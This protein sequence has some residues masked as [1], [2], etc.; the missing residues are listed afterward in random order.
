MLPSSSPEWN[1]F[2]PATTK[3]HG[4]V[5]ADG[6][7]CALL[8]HAQQ[9]VFGIAIPPLRGLRRGTGRG[10]WRLSR[11]ALVSLEGSASS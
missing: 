11:V 9:N 8:E 4:V 2:E 3:A 6:L 1:T 10:T 5:A 7:V